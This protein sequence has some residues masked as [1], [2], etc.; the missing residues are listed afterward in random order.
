MSRI[1]IVDDEKENREA[2]VRALGDSDSSW[3]ILTAKGDVEGKALIE[4]QL[5]K[6]EPIDVVLTDLVMDAEQSGMQ[7]LQ[8]ARK[9]DPLIM[10]I[11]FTAKEKSLDRYA[12]FDFGAFDVVEKNIRGAA[13]VREIITKTR[14]ALKYREWSQR[15][16]FLRR[17]FDPRVFETIERDPS[18]L[19]LRRRMVTICFWD[20]RGFSGLCEILKA[21]PT[22][23][24]G[25]LR[26]YCEVGA[27][28]IFEHGG[29]LDK[30]VGDGIMAVFGVMNHKDDEGKADAIAAAKA[31]LAMRPRFNE[32]V[33]KWTAQWTLYAPQKIEVGL[34][35]GIHT[36][37]SLVGNV[38]TDFRDQ[39]TALGPHVNLAARICGRAGSGQI[40][41]SQSTEA[42]VKASMPTTFVE[43]I[44]DVK[45]IAGKFAVFA[46]SPEK[47][48]LATS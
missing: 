5:E 30:F 33:E 23:I 48:V 19:A 28:T 6:R 43:E 29:V 39:F 26:D 46:L 38:G 22:L 14:A 16:N 7:M 20:I 40:L 1:L 9:L 24:G 45:N 31:A 8:E 36:G 4:A 27:K 32:V 21:H 13:A 35:C 15:I 25:V 44:S 2:L 10:A 47:V 18:V 12:A 42:R 37:E 3:Q 34:G 17:Y 41:L 11:L